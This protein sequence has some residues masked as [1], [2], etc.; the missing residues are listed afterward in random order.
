MWQHTRCRAVW[1]SLAPVTGCTE[2]SCLGANKLH[3]IRSVHRL[4]YLTM[5]DLILDSNTDTV[6]SGSVI[7]TK[8]NLNSTTNLLLKLL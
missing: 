5:L 6:C 7:G 4:I 8:P 1:V 2:G 3:D